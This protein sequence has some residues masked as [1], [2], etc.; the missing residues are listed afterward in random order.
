M[1]FLNLKQIAKIGALAGI[2]GITGCATSPT[3]S[4]SSPPLPT[5]TVQWKLDN[6]QSVGG[7]APTVLGSPQVVNDASGQAIGFNGVDEGLILPVVPITG[8]KAFTVETLIYPQAGGPTEQRYLHTEDEAGNRLTFETR[9]TPAGQW[10]LDTFLLSGRNQLALLN[11][12]KLHP[13]DQWYWV[14]LRYDGA[15][16]T[17]FINGVKEGEGPVVFPAMQEKGQISL[18]VR[19]NKKYWF[20]GLIR[21]VRFTPSA[22]SDAALQRVK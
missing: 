3:Q 5:G 15:T 12:A 14:A 6:L 4:A 13:A 1:K 21:E 2:I 10:A 17:S 18:G 20:K 8:M 22:L 7:S 19:L 16:M 9:L 11:M